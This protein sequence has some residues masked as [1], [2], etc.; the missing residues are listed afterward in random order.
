MRVLQEHLYVVRKEEKLLLSYIWRECWHVL[1]LG[2]MA[3]W[4][5]SRGDRTMD[6]I[7]ETPN[8]RRCM[9]GG[10]FSWSIIIEMIMITMPFF[11]SPFLLSLILLWF[12]FSDPN[13]IQKQFT[14]FSFNVC[15]IFCSSVHDTQCTL[16]D[17]QSNSYS[18]QLQNTEEN[19]QH[20]LTSV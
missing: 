18:G 13:W 15:E 4:L 11:P 10:I 20:E 9:C 12:L 7:M 5:E 14:H 19:Y 1:F 3:L 6:R 8:E 16:M 17:L 2:K